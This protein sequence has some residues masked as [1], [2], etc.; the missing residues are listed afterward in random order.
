MWN[1]PNEGDKALSYMVGMKSR[2]KRDYST[3]KNYKRKGIIVCSEWENSFEKFRDWSFANGYAETLSIDRKDN[4][5]N[6][7]PS[8]CRWAT[9]SEQAN[10]TSHNHPVNINGVVKNISQ[11]ATEYGINKQTIHMRLCNGHTGEELISKA[12]LRRIN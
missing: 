10:N 7:E 6:Y 3:R 4:D 12:I 9:M 11:W 5:G 8:N 2:C 1:P